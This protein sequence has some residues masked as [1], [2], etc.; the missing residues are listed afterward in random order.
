MVSIGPYTEKTNYTHMFD[1][2]DLRGPLPIKKPVKNTLTYFLENH[3]EFSRFYYILKLAKLGHLYADKQANF[4]L[5][6]PTNTCLSY[7][8]EDV[9]V[10]MDISTAKHIIKA[11]TLN[12]RITSDILEDS[13]ASYF[14]T[15]DPTSR[16]FVSN[17]SG[18]T[19]INNTI[20]VVAKDLLMCNG[21]VHIINN[22]IW[23]I[24]P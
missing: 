14:L 22:I 10:N 17:L 11:S 7:I 19:K 24:P 13:P 2:G 4:T 8:P 6:V 9:F 20:D 15:Q 23:P 3:P 5:F 16:L 12:R 18:R 21:I 1:M